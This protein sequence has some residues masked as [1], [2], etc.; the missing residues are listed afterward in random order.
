MIRLFFG[1]LWWLPF[2]LAAL[3]SFLCGF[4][5]RTLGWI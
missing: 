3:I 1:P 2:A 4:L 5:A